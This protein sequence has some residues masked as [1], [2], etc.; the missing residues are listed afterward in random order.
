[1]TESLG[2]HSDLVEGNALGVQDSRASQAVN[3]FSLSSYRILTHSELAPL[4]A[5]LV[6]M[7]HC[8]TRFFEECDPNKDKHIT[9]KEWGHCFGIKEG[10]FIVKNNVYFLR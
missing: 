3:G 8:I 5:S 4:R 7:E 10:K 2:I 6:P 1:M 9:L